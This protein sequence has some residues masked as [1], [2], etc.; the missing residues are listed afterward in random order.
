MREKVSNIFLNYSSCKSDSVVYQSIFYE[1]ILINYR[2]KFIT[3][4]NPTSSYRQ[5]ISAD[6]SND[7]IVIIVVYHFL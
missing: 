3:P 4:L 5:L 7:R 2:I 6:Y 1:I